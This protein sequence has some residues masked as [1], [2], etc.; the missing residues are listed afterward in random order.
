MGNLSKISESLVH[1]ETLIRILTNHHIGN[2]A[3]STNIRN[4]R[5]GKLLV[6]TLQD[7]LEHEAPDDR[8]SEHGSDDAVALAVS[9]VRKVPDVGACDVAELGEG[10]DEGDCDGTLGWWTRE[11]CTDPGVEDDEASKC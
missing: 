2:G 6:Q 5:L 8:E 4:L 11:G 1:P 10:V 7:K 9:V 3:A